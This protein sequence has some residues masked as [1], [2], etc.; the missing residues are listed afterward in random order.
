MKKKIVISINTAWNIYNFRAGLIKALIAQ[1]YDV[2]AIA[3]PDEYSDRLAALG[4]RF[5]ALPMDRNGSH[6]GRDLLLLLRYLHLLRAE[7][8]LVYLGYT[9][10]PN[11]FGS[12]AAHLLR[13]PVVNNIA[14]LGATFISQS[15]LTR[16]VRGLYRLGLSRSYRIFFQNKDDRAMFTETGLAHP[17][18]SECIPGSGINLAHYTP[19]PQRPLLQRPFRFLLVAR[20]LKDKGV[21]EFVEAAR[22]VRRQFPNTVF[23]LLG[24]ID[25]A[26]PNAVS[27]EEIADWER[28][29]LMTYLGKTDDVRP[30]LAAT[31]CVVLPSYREGVPRSLLEAAAMARPIV[32]TD[33]VGCREA[34]DHQ[35]NGLLC[36]I[37][38]AGDLAEKMMQM[39][40]FSPAERL[41]M[42]LAGRKKIET[43]FD[44]RIVIQKYLD[45][46]NEIANVKKISVKNTAAISGEKKVRKP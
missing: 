25:D 23:Q 34:V 21:Y 31:D 32:T 44:E 30:Y 38:D 3:P 40:A 37:K 17:R 9:V 41:T 18:I 22:A 35:V 39:V 36:R 45:V 2:I 33:A 28:E 7:R 8:P 43:E 4:C 15:F 10:K 42:G 14:G 13:I 6:P 16:I 46:I 12:M 27:A 29:G 20:M 24:F 26:N 11:V 1:G 19:M 5:I